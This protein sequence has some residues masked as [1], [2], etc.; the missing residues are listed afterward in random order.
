MRRHAYPLVVVMLAAWVLAPALCGAQET[1]NRLKQE[2]TGLFGTDEVDWENR[3]ITVTAVGTYDPRDIAGP[4]SAQIQARLAA[5]TNAR[6]KLVERNYGVL[7]NAVS[8]KYTNAD[9][10][11]LCAGVIRNA[12]VLETEERRFEDGS[13]MVVVKMQAPMLKIGN[14]LDSRENWE[15]MRRAV[16]SKVKGVSA[17]FDYTGLPAP[18]KTFVEKNLEAVER[19]EDKPAPVP[20]ATQRPVTGLIVDTRQIKNRRVTMLPRIVDETNRRIY[21]IEDRPP[22]AALN[23]ELV[24]YTSSQDKAQQLAGGNPLTVSAMRVDPYNPGHFVVSTADGSAIVSADATSE[25][26]ARGNVILLF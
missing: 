1:P 6:A 25:F 9:A 14:L 19:L 18:Q 12:Q 24:Q 11:L 3:T 10:D 4:G 26:L 23:T 2:Y 17:Q 16:E 21:G 7:V 15:Q 5:E 8:N 13:L 20:N 22:T